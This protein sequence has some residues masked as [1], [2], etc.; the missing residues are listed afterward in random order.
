MTLEASQSGEIYTSTIAYCFM[1]LLSLVQGNFRQ[2][3]WERGNQ[4][5]GDRGDFIESEI[6]LILNAEAYTVFIRLRKTQHEEK[7]K[8]T[9]VEITH[10]HT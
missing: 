10:A 3:K 7:T 2:R 9:D 1:G 4:F 5:E 8:R 6:Q